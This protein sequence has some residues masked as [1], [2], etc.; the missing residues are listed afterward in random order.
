MLFRSIPNEVPALDC[1][2]NEFEGISF[3]SDGIQ[4]SKHFNLGQLSSRAVVVKEKVAAQRGLTTGQIVCN[5]KNL[6]VNCLDKIKDKYPDMIVTNAFRLDVA[7]R[8]N[9]S[10]HGM[11]M[12]ADLQFPSI[13]PSQYYEI[14][15]W[16]AENVPYKIGRA[17]V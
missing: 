16:I 10:D 11:G 12:A 15:N 1:D 17:H 7:S 3:F 14:I 4:L 5:L 8:S 13:R 9:V 6:A 2:C